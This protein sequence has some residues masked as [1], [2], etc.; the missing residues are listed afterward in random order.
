V[1]DSSDLLIQIKMKM[2]KI[3]IILQITIV[4]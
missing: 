2:M 4:K 3:E 1:I